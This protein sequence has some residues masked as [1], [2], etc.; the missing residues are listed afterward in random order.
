MEE[1]TL[2]QE[3]NH[4]HISSY[5][6]LFGVFAGLVMLTVMTVLF[7]S[8]WITLG[9]LS[10]AMALFIA[11]AKVTLVALHFMHLKYDSKMYR[12]MI[13]VVIGLFVFFM[14]MITIDYLTR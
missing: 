4:Q 12:W 10:V 2:I 8:I 3:E 5:R 6:D 1:K 9:S 7:S 14:V 11:S 13:A